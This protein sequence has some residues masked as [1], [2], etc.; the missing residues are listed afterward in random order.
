MEN[1]VNSIVQVNDCANLIKIVLPPK[2]KLK[3]INSSGVLYHRSAG[4]C[5]SVRAPDGSACFTIPL[6]IRFRW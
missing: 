1:K 6:G 2:L 3:N 4:R 5:A